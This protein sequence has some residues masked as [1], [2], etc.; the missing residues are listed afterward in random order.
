M[1]TTG[2]DVSRIAYYLALAGG[3]LM[4]LFGLLGFFASFGVLYFY[5]GFSYGSIVTVI[6]GIIAVIGA[7]S[8]DTLVWAIVLNNCWT[9][10]R[11]IRRFACIAWRHIWIEYDFV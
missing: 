10:W 9:C 11:R 5:W 8:V 6:M 7:R 3:I 1:N 2:N 4:I